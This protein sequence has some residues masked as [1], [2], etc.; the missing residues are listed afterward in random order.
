MIRTHSLIF[1]PLTHPS[2]LLPTL[3]PLTLPVGVD[4]LLGY[5]EGKQSHL[6]YPD[7]P[8]H[9]Q[10]PP[11]ERESHRPSSARGLGLGSK[12]APGS[13]LGLE[14]YLPSLPRQIEMETRI[15][16]LGRARATTTT[17]LSQDILSGGAGADASPHTYAQQFLEFSVVLES[18][19]RGVRE[20]LKLAYLVLEFARYTHRSKISP[21]SK[22]MKV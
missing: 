22:I 1:L 6:H 5:D 8:D 13:G 9:H 19:P 7:H 14:L 3:L 4:D 21:R 11:Y 12:P 20:A 10:Y 16:Y 17:T 15:R 18:D 2:T